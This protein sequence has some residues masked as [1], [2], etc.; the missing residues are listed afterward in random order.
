MSEPSVLNG[1][2]FLGVMIGVCF[3]WFLFNI[4]NIY[5]TNKNQSKRRFNKYYLEDGSYLYTD[6]KRLY[7]KES[8]EGY[9]LSKEVY[10]KVFK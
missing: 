3:S 9:P 4:L 1:V 8:V 7:S 6:G 10:E 2:L 5:F